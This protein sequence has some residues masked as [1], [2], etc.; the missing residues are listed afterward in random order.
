MDYLKV[1]SQPGHLTPGSSH[2]CD[3]GAIQPAP[4]VEPSRSLTWAS[5]DHQLYAQTPRTPLG[6]LITEQHIN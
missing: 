2:V 3:Q 4:K 5:T 1:D 6:P